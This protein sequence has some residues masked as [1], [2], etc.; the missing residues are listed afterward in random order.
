MGDGAVV[1]CDGEMIT[2]DEIIDRLGVLEELKEI[3]LTIC[4]TQDRIN[5]QCQKNN[6]SLLELL[7]NET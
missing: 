5:K 3:M 2:I 7:K 1:L 4:E 6:N